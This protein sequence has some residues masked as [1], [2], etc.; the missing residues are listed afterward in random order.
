MLVL[1][2]GNNKSVKMLSN[3]GTITLDNQAK[4]SYTQSPD[5]LV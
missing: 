4:V 1:F 2:T 5:S 3:T